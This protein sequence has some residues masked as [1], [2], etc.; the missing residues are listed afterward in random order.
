MPSLAISMDQES[1]AHARPIV[2]ISQ[3]GGLCFDI[4]NPELSNV[5]PPPFR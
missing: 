4:V 3:I 5:F 2:D 1:A